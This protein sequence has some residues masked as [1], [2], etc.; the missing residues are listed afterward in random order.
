MGEAVVVVKK[1]IPKTTGG[2]GKWMTV[3][4]QKKEEV[5]KALCTIL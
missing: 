1:K 4:N 3:S 5:V 2:D